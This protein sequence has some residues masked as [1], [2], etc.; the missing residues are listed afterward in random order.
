MSIFGLDNNEVDALLK[1]DLEVM[2]EAEATVVKET[3]AVLHMIPAY[4]MKFLDNV[5]CVMMN[6]LFATYG[7]EH[8]KNALF[9]H[10]QLKTK[11]K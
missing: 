8:V 7:E 4:K 6:N 11:I 3:P 5:I 10:Y 2:A 9:T 1:K